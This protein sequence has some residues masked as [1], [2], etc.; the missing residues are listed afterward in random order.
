MRVIYATANI[1]CIC[2]FIMCCNIKCQ[3]NKS[4]SKCNWYLYMAQYDNGAGSTILKMDLIKYATPKEFPY[5]INNS[6]YV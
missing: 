5:T 3:E 6:C 4:V 2:F 1:L